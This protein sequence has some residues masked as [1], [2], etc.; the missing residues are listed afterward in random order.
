MAETRAPLIQTSLSRQALDLLKR[1]V[2]ILRQELLRQWVRHFGRPLEWGDWLLVVAPHPDDEVLGCGGL[3]ALAVARGLEVSVVI[4]TDGESSHIDCCGLDPLQVAAN[5]RQ[6]TLK[7]MHALSVPESH[8]TFLHWRDE[9]V[10]PAEAKGF[11]DKARALASLVRDIEPN[12]VFCP[13]LLEEGWPDHV[14]AESLTRTAVQASGVSCRVFHYCVWFW[15]TMPLKKAAYVHWSGARLL[16]ISRVLDQKKRVIRLYTEPLA[17]CGNPW[18]GR[19]P[20]LFLRACGW[21]YELFF[22]VSLAR[23]GRDQN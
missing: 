15:H 20:S 16:N 11:S 13:H 3:I 9:Q 4:L 14:A 2:R 6:L 5:R 18:S 10:P 22:E 17:P 7:A 23:S 21:H 12:M 1:P 19:L 8:V